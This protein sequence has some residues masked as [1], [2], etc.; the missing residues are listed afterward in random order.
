MAIIYQEKERIFTL[1]TLHT[2]Y[3]MK[4][5]SRGELLH[6][7]YGKKVSGNLDYLLPFFD[8]SF[9]GNPGDAGN[10]RTY[11]LDVLPLE[12]PTLGVGDYR[13]AA[14]DIENGDGTECVDLRY[15]SHEI[16]KGKYALRGLPA[17]F[18][19]EEEA[20]TLSVLLKDSV[21]GVQVELLYGVLESE[22]IIT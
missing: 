10:D 17:V 6:L 20:Q 1:E 7:Y 21:N 16:K 12:Y 13:A 4:A 9:S 5:D 11:S 3:Q 15:Y 22:D 8:R 14:L 18:A 19:D 2:T